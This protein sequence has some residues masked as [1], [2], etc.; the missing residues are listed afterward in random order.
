MAAT[1]ATS[2]WLARR[3]PRAVK[4][5]LRP[6]VRTARGW[7]R[8]DGAGTQNRPIRGRGPGAVEPM[9]PLPTRAD[10]P[11]LDGWYHTIELAPGLTSRGVFDHRGVA[12]RVGLD[13]S[14]RGRTALDVGTADGFWAF[15]LERRGADRV[16]AID[17]PS[18]GACDFLPT[19]LARMDPAD[20]D[21]QGWPRRFATAHRMRGSRV[22]YRFC[23][24]YDLSP[25]TVGGTF[26][27]V[28]C[29][30]LL[31]HLKNPLQA[32]INIRSVTRRTAV[33]VTGAIGGHF[34]A[35]FPDQSILRFGHLHAEEAPGDNNVY[36]E[37]S[38]KAL[39]DMLIYAGF[40]AVELR[41]KLV[42]AS[43]HP[44]SPPMYEAVVAVAHV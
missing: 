20:K 17:V 43:A 24:V 9:L 18:L 2:S 13:A 14:L 42:V 26:D 11:R 15:E 4:P 1:S 41:E 40:A 5:M 25:A 35:A 32:L 22:E 37:F 27:V 16:V 10:D 38:R 12:D 8:A 19:K 39:R 7:L 6:I 29:G 28:Y 33:V 36:W 30:D 21:S 31:L 3:C 44:G 23:S 34:E